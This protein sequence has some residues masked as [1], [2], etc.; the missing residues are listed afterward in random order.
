MQILDF[1]PPIPLKNTSLD[2][3]HR[4][5]FIYIEPRT[6]DH[7]YILI[8]S[9]TVLRIIILTNVPVMIR[10]RSGSGNLYFVFLHHVL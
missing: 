2:F 10:I 4:C 8:G 5:Y 6:T 9:I 3:I 7:T 1:I